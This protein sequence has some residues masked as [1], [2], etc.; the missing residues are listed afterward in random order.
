MET[1]IMDVCDVFTKTKT[2][3]KLIE[4]FT[5]KQRAEFDKG[6][7]IEDALNEIGKKYGFI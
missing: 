5:P 3:V 7:S 2:P 4:G 1:A 6:I